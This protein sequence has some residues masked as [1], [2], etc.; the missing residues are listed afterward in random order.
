MG[1]VVGRPGLVC[2]ASSQSRHG[3]NS[4][5]RGLESATFLQ[6]IVD[7]HNVVHIAVAKSIIER[8]GLGKVRH[9][10]ANTLWWQERKS[11][12]RIPLRKILGASNPLNLVAQPSQE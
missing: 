8:G 4:F 11:R 6:Y 1:A 5:I 10:H 7:E 2:A 9:I 3:G 12:S